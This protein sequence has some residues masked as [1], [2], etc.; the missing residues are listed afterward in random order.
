MFGEG[1]SLGGTSVT[2]IP[3]PKAEH[4]HRS[5]GSKRSSNTPSLRAGGQRGSQGTRR[6]SGFDLLTVP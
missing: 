4:K 5:R 6:E 3:L 2:S 1:C